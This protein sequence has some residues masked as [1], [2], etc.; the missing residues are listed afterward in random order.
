MVLAISLNA[1][2][3]LWAVDSDADDVKMADFGDNNSVFR[4]TGMPLPPKL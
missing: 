4:T 3:F 2:S 1:V